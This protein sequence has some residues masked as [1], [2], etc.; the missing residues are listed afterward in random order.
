MLVIEAKNNFITNP[1]DNTTK[2]SEFQ[3]VNSV[4]KNNL[5]DPLVLLLN[6][7]YDG[8]KN[9]WQIYYV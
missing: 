8:M 6:S 9:K 2:S 4:I 5:Y 3:I 7:F 1:S